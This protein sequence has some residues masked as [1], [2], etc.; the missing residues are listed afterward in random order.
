MHDRYLTNTRMMDYR[1]DC[2]DWTVAGVV[3]LI[4]RLALVALF[5]WAVVAVVKYI[6]KYLNAKSGL[7]AMSAEEIAKRRFAN[8]EITKSEYDQ[9][10]KDLK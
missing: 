9:L 2:Y 5:I 10:K 3:E 7:E 6:V 8:G 1:N 4:I